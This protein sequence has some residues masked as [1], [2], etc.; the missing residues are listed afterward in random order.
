MIF[1]EEIYLYNRFHELFERA[2][3]AGM[4][5]DVFLSYIEDFITQFE[6]TKSYNVKRQLEDKEKKLKEVQQLFDAAEKRLKKFEQRKKY[7]IRNY[8]NLITNDNEFE[9]KITKL[10][11]QQKADAEFVAEAPNEIEHLKH[12]IDKLQSQYERAKKITLF[13]ISTLQFSPTQVQF[14]GK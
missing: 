1:R 10:N 9:Q 8:E 12:E 5:E 4:A 13:A 2:R 7:H 14:I 6:S 3:N 11:E